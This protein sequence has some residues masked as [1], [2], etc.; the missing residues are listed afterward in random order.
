MK[1]GRN[2]SCW[3]GSGKKYKAC[4]ADFDAFIQIHQ[5]NSLRNT[6]VA[7]NLIPTQTDNN[8]FRGNEH[9]FLILLKQQS[10]RQKPCPVCQLVY[11]QA[12]AAAVLQ[13]KLRNI[14]LFRTDQ[15]LVMVT[16]QGLIKKTDMASFANIRKM[17]LI[18]LNLREGRPRLCSGSY[19]YPAA[20]A[21]HNSDLKA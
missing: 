8:A 20:Y 5:L 6:P 3:C 11:F 13:I 19:K 15:Y 21:L 17:G 10:A 4:H 14:C 1:F 12:N 2:D 18:A 7:G 9:D 16:K